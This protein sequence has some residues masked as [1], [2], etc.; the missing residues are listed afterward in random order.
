MQDFHPSEVG[1]IVGNQYMRGNLSLP[2]TS[3]FLRIRNIL[4]ILLGILLIL[5]M[6]LSKSRIYDHAEYHS[7]VK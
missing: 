2:S 1:K 7:I 6:P 4:L 5:Y 3:R